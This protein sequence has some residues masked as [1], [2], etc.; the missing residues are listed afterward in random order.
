MKHILIIYLL[1]F[2][3]IFSYAFNDN[4]F[5]TLDVKSGI[6]DNYI[7]S[8]LKDKYGFMWFASK[9]GL[10][11]Y[12][13]YH[14]KKYTTL[15]LGSYNNSIEWIKEDASGNVWIK[16]PVNYCYYNRE[17]DRF[18]NDFTPI[19]NHF[20]I[21]DR[22]K[23]LFID[24]DQ[25][26]WIVANS[27]I[28]Y[29][30]FKR[31]EKILIEKKDKRE[32]LDLTCNHEN[33][34]IL[35]EDGT[36][37]YLNKENKRF[38]DI[39]DMQ[40]P[41]NLTHN[42]FLD[43]EQFLWIYST[44]GKDLYCYSP[45]EKKMIDYK[46]K[47]EIVKE[48]T[49]ITNVEEDNNGNIWIGSDNK[50]I[51]ITNIFAGTFSHIYKRP[52]K[53]YSLPSNHITCFFKDDNGI[54]WVGTSKQG[55]IYTS[56]NSNVFENHNFENKEDISCITEDDKG[57]LWLGFDGEGIARIDQITGKQTNYKAKNGEIPS[58]LIVCSFK[59]SQN[60]IWWGSFGYGAFYYK[61]GK[62]NTVPYNID[63][64][65]T[66]LYIRR[67][68]EDNMGNIWFA[69]FTQGIFCLK[70]DGSLEQFNKFNSSIIT[71]Y[72][73]DLSC[74]DG[75][76]LYIATSSGFFCM[77]IHSKY[78]TE[79]TENRY[80]QKFAHG[81]FVNCLYHDS[82]GL[83][84]IGG[85]D[86]LNIYNKYDDNIYSLTVAD[87]LSNNNIRA[88]Y[89]DGNKNV[90][91]S[92]DH[93][94]SHIKISKDHISNI[95]NFYCFPYFEKDGIGNFT[96]NNFS[97]TKDK[98]D[99]IIVGGSGG[100]LKIR[101]Q[102]VDNVHTPD[103]IMFTGFFLGN[104]RI[105]VGDTLSDGRVLFDKNIQLMKEISLRHS[106][107][108]FSLEF[109]ALTYESLH[110]IQYIYRLSNSD[111]WIN[112]EGNRIFFNKLS[113]GT[114]KLEVK[115]VEKN[116]T[117][118]N[119][120][121]YFVIKIEPPI[122]RSPKAFILYI[123]L[124]VV[125]IITTI[126][127]FK[128]HHL[129]ILNQQKNEMEIIRE[130]DMNE[131]KMKF[132]TNVSHDLRTPLS[133]IITPA[134]RLIAQTSKSEKED[135]KLIHRNAN[136]LMEEINQ[137]L[138]FRKMDQN[139]IVF[140]PSFSNFS[141]FVNEI[142]KSYIELGSISNGVTIEM[143][144]K[145]DEIETYFDKMKM[146]RVIHNILS[147]AVKYNI[148]NG[149]IKVSLE[150][151][152]IT[153]GPG[154]ISLSIADTGIG[155]KNK[156]RIFDRFY[157]EHSNTST[158]IG[159]GIG[160]NIVK[161]YIEIHQGTVTVADNKPQGSIFTITLPIKEHMTN[162]IMEDS[163]NS[164][165][166]PELSQNEKATLLIVEDNDDFRGFINSC[167]CDK[168]NIIE[169]NDGISAL[170]MLSKHSNI[171]IIISDVMMPNMNGLELCQ[172]VKQ[173]INYSHIPI[174]LLTARTAQ[175]HILDGLRE[176][177][178]DYITKPFNVD[179]LL[180]RVEKILNWTSG[181]HNKFGKMEITPS[182][183]TVSRLDEQLIDKAISEVEKNMDNSEFTVEDLS[184]A[185]G[186]T[187]GHLYKKLISITGKSPIEFIRILRLKRGKQL[188]EQSQR[189]I[190]EISYEVGLSPKQFAKYFKD[191]FG[192]SPSIYK[193]ENTGLQI[194]E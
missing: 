4:N 137:L 169:A 147:N 78:I 88:I 43:S 95:Y 75:R 20:G 28:Y 193:K 41:Q 190:S 62:F 91:V 108:N 117:I 105:E 133:L 14:F 145:Q 156:E 184:A 40:L 84:W 18:E 180:L 54:M 73:A 183:I 115:V 129:R 177:A 45:Y 122:W 135:L 189:S 89:G 61:D 3:N 123:I 176:G 153:P 57:I 79:L 155:I 136:L 157:Q 80:G 103:T 68:T 70:K 167:L 74:N 15:H 160:L 1:I 107:N 53:L 104:D 86:G 128:R 56:L 67:I 192:V 37:A 99:N 12:D 8:I 101:K 55:V 126:I 141:A 106:D 119:K 125:I 172:S 51:Y 60:R 124:F 39:I 159:S 171:K 149:T 134:E 72:I 71:N 69:T 112:I 182:E 151:I 158:Y 111:D 194:E 58:D 100:Y 9:N 23:K 94:I 30:N 185:V 187:R 52:K 98:A 93:G 96:F 59:D 166:E 191:E 17:L 24:K 132:F 31:Q 186:M 2:C 7:Q 35:L 150:K 83:L 85:R 116:N 152:N 127:K 65:N 77:D 146:K 90:W 161:E 179:I 66:P 10:D 130:R 165:D 49:I 6:S 142:C 140:N 47:S 5:N 162:V 50:G 102:L 154:V 38:E 42:V 118:E 114:Y 144:I 164:I 44:H 16:T 25:N 87:G 163:S 170:D 36:I 29:Y 143:Y 34:Y 11:R 82:Y 33:A 174:I 109:S 97:M 21:N 178:D 148:K 64:E 131:S 63:R 168:Y 113:P 173:N 110:K 188:I 121:A 76:N 181:N 175:E 92:T 46:G 138:D 120:P 48:N 139:K 13:G 27:C 22:V 19:L 81:N 32:I 26:L